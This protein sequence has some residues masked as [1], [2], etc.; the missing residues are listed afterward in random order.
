MNAP[1]V[2]AIVTLI[3]GFIG[4]LR[5]AFHDEGRVLNASFTQSLK[6]LGKLYTGVGT[7][8]FGG[9]LASK[10]NWRES[11]FP[12]AYLFL[13]RFLAVPVISIAT[14]YGLRKRF[15]HYIRQDPMLDFVLAISHSGPPA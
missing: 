13:W 1:L 10:K 14:V 12:L 3:I 11:I 4:P 7:F 8:F 5:R 9:S 15:P 6:T 2:T